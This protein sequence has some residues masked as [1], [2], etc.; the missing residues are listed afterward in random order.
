MNHISGN[1]LGLVQFAFYVNDT[2]SWV[3]VP[4]DPS[5]TI[6]E[7][8]NPTNGEWVQYAFKE[9]MYLLAPLMHYYT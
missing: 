6:H 3:Y 5:A 4:A 2:Q 1:D 7:N 8:A 9:L